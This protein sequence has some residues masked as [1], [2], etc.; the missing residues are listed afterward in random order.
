MVGA[1]ALL[2]DRERPGIERLGLVEAALGAIE[3]GQVVEGQRELRV[4]SAP[5]VVSLIAMLRW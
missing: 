2:V 4:G 3:L 5:S 1:E